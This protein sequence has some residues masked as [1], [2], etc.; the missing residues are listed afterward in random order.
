MRDWA[1]A[2]RG[3]PRHH[4]ERGGLVQK[5]SLVGLRDDRATLL[6]AFLPSVDTLSEAEDAGD[7]RHH[8]VTRSQYRCVDADH[9]ALSLQPQVRRQEGI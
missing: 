3:R 7:N 2:Q 5:A 8:I 9:A 6:G 4:I 1:N